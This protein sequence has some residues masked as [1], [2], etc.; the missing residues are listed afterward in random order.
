MRTV[1]TVSGT[2]ENSDWHQRE[3]WLAPVRTVNGTSENSELHQW[4]QWMAPARTVDENSENKSVLKILKLWVLKV[5]GKIS[6]GI[7]SMLFL[8]SITIQNWILTL[9]NRCILTV[10]SHWPHCS[11]PLVPLVPPLFS[12]FS[13]SPAKTVLISWKYWSCEKKIF[14]ECHQ[15]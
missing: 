15:T 3:Q 13:L 7:Q 12:L 10:L 11:H 14:L 6:N 2:S 5:A 4:E 9:L 1:R 8:K